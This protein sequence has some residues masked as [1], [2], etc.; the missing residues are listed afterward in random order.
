MKFFST[1]SM[2]ITTATGNI[3]SFISCAAVFLQ[4]NTG[5]IADLYMKVVNVGKRKILKRK[6]W[7]SS[8]KW[9]FSW[10]GFL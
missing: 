8:G 5:Q 2:Q 7:K 9:D 4:E 6:Y 10:R 3:K 1:D